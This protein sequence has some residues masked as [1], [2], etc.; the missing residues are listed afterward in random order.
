[1]RTLPALFAALIAGASLGACSDPPPP[2]P[3]AGPDLVDACNSAAEAAANEDCRL[4]LDGET[5]GYLAT[6][7]DVDW[8]VLDVETLPARPILKVAAEYRAPSTP[9]TLSV[10]VVRADGNSSI[11]SAF[12][13]KLRGGPGPVEVT[14][15]LT[16][17]GRYFVIVRHDT[18]LED[19]ALD[20][21]NP[22][23]LTAA[24][25]SDPD[26]H[27]PN[28]EEATEVALGPCATARIEG[29]LA[30]AG[31]VD[32]YTFDVG[33]CQGRTILHATFRAPK[34]SPAQIRL[35][36]E[37]TGPE[38]PVAADRASSPFN[39][40]TLVTARLVPNGTYEIEVKAYQPPNSIG[41]P[42]G[43]PEFVYTI[44]LALFSDSD[45]NEGSNG[46]DTPD[47]ATPIALSTG[48]TRSVTGRISYV[49][50]V[51]Y[52]QVPLAASP[53]PRR[54]HYRL[55][56][57]NAA[58]RFPSV[59]TLQPK[60]LAV[61]TQTPSASACKATCPNG[62]RSPAAD[63]CNR[64]QCLWQRRV[65]DPQ[66]DFRN[67]EGKLLVPA[68]VEGP[69]L[70]QV[71]YIGASGADDTEY[72]LTLTLE[73]NSAEESTTMRDTPATAIP[74]AAGAIGT[75]VL[76]HGHG[77]PN[78]SAGRAANNLSPIPRS[79]GDYD[80]QSDTDFFVVNF[81]P[82]TPPPPPDPEEDDGTEVELPAVALDLGWT[83]PPTANQR[84]GERSH[85]ISM[86]LHFCETPEC[87]SLVP[88]RSFIGYRSGTG[89][90]WYGQ[91]LDP[92]MPAQRGFDF[93]QST[94]TF[95]VRDSACLCIDGQ[96][97]AAGKLFVEVRADNR[98]SYEDV[99]VQL[100]VGVGDYPRDFIDDAGNPM[101]C[102][103]PC[104]FVERSR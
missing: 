50:D 18:S 35:A 99:D 2:I 6:L 83:I 100:R 42:P 84:A 98:A 46:N 80:A 86:R 62:D 4:P 60:E 41:V 102:P 44:D 81:T 38:G 85:D 48:Q 57:S 47:R 34:P 40:Q 76:G 36:Y 23:F 22:Y 31:D 73:E 71:G 68:N 87:T 37:L 5:Q 28:D 21:R 63:W 12:D 17:A 65:E 25:V 11:G 7:D 74:V 77:Q 52:F 103:V 67:F 75:T 30:T 51:D 16:E 10:N 39:E 94:G 9:V 24:L 1:M 79:S 70:F 82:P 20:T 93:D 13:R 27:E 78:L 91:D 97:A 89:S 59:P 45:P 15:R 49:P 19:P 32:R 64:S 54:I 61:L 8:Y 26:T 69:W 56:W 95:R 72:T 66:I 92:Q 90:V 14:A 58:G 55:S 43:D 29:A 33:G 104:R 3:D 101:S 53:T 88:L 96:Y